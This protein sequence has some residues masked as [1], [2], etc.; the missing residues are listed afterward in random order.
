[1][2]SKYTRT[3]YPTGY[4]MLED[5]TVVRS[6]PIWDEFQKKFSKVLE[7]A[8]KETLDDNQPVQLPLPGEE[9]RRR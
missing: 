5:G 2:K 9:S 3:T 8:A 1:M 4:V 6:G 7:R